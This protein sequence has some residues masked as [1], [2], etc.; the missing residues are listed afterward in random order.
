MIA[1]P[2]D[3]IFALFWSAVLSLRLGDPETARSQCEEAIR[4]L[5]ER[6]L[7]SFFD[8]N[9]F[10]RGWAV[11]QL[12]QV[13]QGLSEML[14]RGMGFATA[15]GVIRPLICEGLANIYLADGRRA[16]GLREVSDA[17]E[18]IQHSGTTIVEAELRRLKGELLLIGN[19]G[20][21]PEA[22]QCFRDA[23]EVARRQSAKSWELR[24]TMSLARLL[25]NQG[26]HDEA[27]AMLTD[28]YNWFTEGFDTVDLKDAKTLLGELA[29]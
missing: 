27:R 21:E 8:L 4:L 18:V 12:G 25:N 24:A 22:A 20:T 26:R 14:Q 28:V 16:E 23:I 29:G 11:A 2:A 5:H 19:N 9:G 7:V 6:G 1:S 3:L 10:W 13:E 15:S 17:L